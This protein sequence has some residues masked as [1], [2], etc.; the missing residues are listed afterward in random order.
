MRVALVIYG[1]L[2][3]VS[4]GYLYDRKLVEYLTHQ[5]DEVEIISLPWR[6][7]AR[8]LADNLSAKWRRRLE[9]D[10]DVIVQD[11]LNHPSLVWINNHLRQPAPL[12]AIVHHL[13]CSEPRPPWQN[14][15]YRAIERR[16]L[17]SV[18]AFIF[19]SRSTKR[20]VSE[21][22]AES[23]PYIIAHPAGDRFGNTIATEEIIRRAYSGPLQLLFVGNLIP[24]KGLHTLLSALGLCQSF[25]WQLHVVGSLDVEP[26]YTDQIQ[27]LLKRWKLEERVTLSGV[28]NGEDLAR[29]MASAHL[30]VMP[31]AYEGFGIVYLEGMGFGLPAIATTAGAAGELIADGE[32]GFTIPPDNPKALANCLLTLAVDRDRLAQ[33]SLAA[34][35]RYA[36]HP[37]WAD[38]TA[39][40]RQFLL[41]L[42]G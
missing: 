22:L 32:N 26:A 2:D 27:N 17:N 5:G 28:L 42:T 4:G 3:T 30:M 40:I 41:S 34:L 38:S 36:C 6:N 7:Y 23:K 24:R 33:M 16:Y 9:G 15:V 11:E 35:V 20:V 12:V 1:S 13:R 39:A 14:R 18:D 19:N 29:E 37:T 25:Q 10:F 8:H 21:L 31:S